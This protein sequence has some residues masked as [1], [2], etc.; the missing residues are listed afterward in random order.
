MKIGAR[1]NPSLHQDSFEIKQVQA[2]LPGLIFCLAGA[3]TAWTIAGFLPGV[4]PLIVAIILGLGAANL[5]ALPQS[6]SAGIA[7][8]AKKVL[9]WGIVFLGLKIVAGDIWDLGVPLLVV[10]VTVVGGGIVGTVLVGRLM[11]VP[12]KLAILIG[13]GFSICGAAAVAGV[14]GSIEAEDEDVVTAVALVVL[15]G[16]IMIPLVPL[17]A[18]LLGFGVA[19]AGQLVGASVLEVAQVV[20][21]GEII[22]G[23]GLEI[24]VVTKLARVVLLAPVIFVFALLERRRDS[25]PVPA[26]Q[27]DQA[28]QKSG[29][30]TA[31]LVPMFVVGFLMMV[32]LASVADLP[33]VVLAGG[34]A[35]Q[36][37]LLSTAMFA[38][39]CGVKLKNLR[40][41]GVKPFALAVVAATLSV[42]IAAVGVSLTQIFV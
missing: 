10:V 26:S 16:T 37:M 30:R 31:P 18:H 40:Q 4:S 29:V 33:E 23:A 2:T 20:A 34:A 1:L 6:W 27:G 19:A 42:T 11:G 9:R 38:L 15:F 5:F 7:V 35:A 3:A 41:V 28:R 39:G 14:E 8:S 36:T 17:L 12:R 24:A 21:A 32:A 13:C 25:L 22:G